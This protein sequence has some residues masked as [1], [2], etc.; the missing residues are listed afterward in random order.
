MRLTREF[1]PL[2]V[3]DLLRVVLRGLVV[4]GGVAVAV[5][6]LLQF[7]AANWAVYAVFVIIYVLVALPDVEVLP[8]L[9]LPIPNMAATIGFLYIGGLPILLLRDLSPFL[10]RLLLRALPSDWREE[11]TTQRLGGG[12]GLFVWASAAEISAAVVA[13]WATFAIGMGVRW[14]IVEAVTAGAPTSAEPAAIA[15]AELGG[16]A[17]WGLLSI[18]PVYP[19]RPL[20]PLSTEKRGLQAALSDIGLVVVLAVTPFVFLINYGYQAHGLHGA[21]AWALS[22]FG[23]HFML[24]RLN[25][26]RLRLEAQNRRLEELNR[27]LEHR[28]RLSAIGKMS[29]VVSHQILHQLGVIGIYADLIRNAEG[30]NGSET[31]L[32][33]A[34]E[35]AQAIEDALRNV[36]RVVTDLLVFSKDLR[37]NL[38]EHPLK[39]VIEECLEDCRADAAERGVKVRCECLQEATA[40]LDKLK[41]K[42]AITNVLRNAIEVSPAGSEVLARG[43]VADGVAEIVISDHGPGVPERDREAIFTPFFTTK[44]QGT[45]L[46]LA[47]AREFTEAHGGTLAYRPTEGQRGATF[48]FR[49]PLEK[50]N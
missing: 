35:N 27:E 7:R 49:L 36:N 22:T 39:R 18:L 24:K 2:R 13:E 32:T 46:G 45:G 25:E 20:L 42:Q 21:A 15:L 14:W 6:A 4:L 48:V 23:L 41:I 50:K 11:L 30:E 16:H 10:A 40:V 5:T 3:S 34:R 38:Y 29:S 47:I 12:R 17:A 33:Q 31:T 19:D 43:E 26:R 37:L 1:R 44:E 9:R 8:A 28:E